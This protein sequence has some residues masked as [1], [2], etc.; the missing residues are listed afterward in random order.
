MQSEVARD[1]GHEIALKLVPSQ[2]LAKQTKAVSAQAFDSYP[3]LA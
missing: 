1:I 3:P 2:A